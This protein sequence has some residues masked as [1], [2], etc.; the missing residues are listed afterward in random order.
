MLQN[1]CRWLA[2]WVKMIGNLVV[3]FAALFAVIQRNSTDV[4]DLPISA[5]LIGLSI[6]YALEVNQHLT[7]VLRT[8]CD[9]ETNS[10]AVERVTEYSEIAT[11]APVIVSDHRP[12]DD[13]PSRG[14][15]RFEHYSTRYRKGLDLVLRDIS[16][17]IAGGTKVSKIKLVERNLQALTQFG[18]CSEGIPILSVSVFSFLITGWGCRSDRCW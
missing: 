3:F 6:T 18:F 14:Q 4:I 17:N 7:Y 10:I 11:E 16:V 8:T 12:P 13:W 2:N 5:S 1:G 15:I 9:L